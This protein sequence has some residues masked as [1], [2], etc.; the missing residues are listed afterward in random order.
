M[1]ITKLDVVEKEIE[2]REGSPIYREIVRHGMPSVAIQAGEE[3]QLMTVQAET[4]DYEIRK[5][6]TRSGETRYYAIRLDKRG[7]W[8]LYDAI[9]E[10]K[11]EEMKKSL[12]RIGEEQGFIQ[13]KKEGIN[14]AWQRF[15]A[16]PWYKRLFTKLYK[17]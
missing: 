10:Q 8:E 16:L 9:S 15:K 11:F 6:R 4:I 3:P 2:V 1:R 7:T 12:I 14:M 17:D 13:G 5:V